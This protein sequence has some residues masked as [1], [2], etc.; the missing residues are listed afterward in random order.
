MK[1]ARRVVLALGLAWLTPRLSWASPY[2]FFPGLTELM[3][4][5][6]SIVVAT[7]TG[8]IYHQDTGGGAIQEIR[9]LRSIKG[10]HRDGSTVQAYL[11]PLRLRVGVKEEHALCPRQKC[12]RFSVGDRYVIFLVKDKKFRWPFAYRPFEYSTPSI[13][14]DSF[15]VSPSFDLAGLKE[16]DIRE[17]ISVLLRDA[18]A[19]EKRAKT[20]QAALLDYEKGVA[21]YLGS[22]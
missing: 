1:G 18:V 13:S 17:N 10:N 14:G 2:R 7:P 3:S 6:D 4:T 16:G 8:P 5:S 22:K 19:Y 9:V 21:V 20:N 15:W 12:D 11:R